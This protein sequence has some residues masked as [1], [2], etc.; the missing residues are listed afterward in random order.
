MIFYFLKRFKSYN[1][2]IRSLIKTLKRIENFIIKNNNLMK[3][4]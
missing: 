1:Q 3:L 2:I 4:E